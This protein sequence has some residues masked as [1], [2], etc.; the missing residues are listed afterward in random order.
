MPSFQN[1]LCL[2][3]CKLV[4]KRVIFPWQPNTLTGQTDS[5]GEICLI[6]DTYFQ[7]HKYTIRTQ[8]GQTQPGQT[9]PGQDTTQTGTQPGHGQTVY[10]TRT[11]RK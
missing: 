11:P 6:F 3:D 2:F 9:Q 8:P 1:S 4:N 10:L 5:F 7:S